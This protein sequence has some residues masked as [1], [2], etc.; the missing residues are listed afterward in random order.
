MANILLGFLQGILNHPLVVGFYLLI[1]ILLIAFRKKFTFQGKIIALYRTK[2][3]LGLMDA[4]AGKHRELVKL[5]GYIGIGAGFLSMFYILFVLAQSVITLLTVPGTPAPLSPVLPG[6]RIPGVPEGFFIPF[7]QGIIAIFVIAV[8]HEFAHGVVARAHDIKIKSSGPAI[9][10]PIFAAF[11]EP[12]EAQ[13]KRKDDV[14][15]LSVFAAGTFSNI[16]LTVLILLVMGIVFAPLNA[17]VFQDVGVTVTKVEPGFPAAASGLPEG[18]KIAALNGENVN[19]SMDARTILSYARPGQTMDFSD[20]SAH[21]AVTATKHPNNAR[22]GYFG[23][24][25]QPV[26]KH[27]NSIVFK[28]YSW[29]AELLR[30]IMMLSVGIGLANMIPAG[31]LDGGKMLHLALRRVRGEGQANKNLIQVSIV[32][33][34]VV[35]FLL[36]P[37]FKAILK[38]IF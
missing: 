23:I 3:G 7:I 38:A 30:L 12:D 8:V 10:G 1:I 35:I 20:G 27:Q 13:M 37:I 15:N 29:I 9:I 19:S 6:V 4:I 14:A 36:S 5:F 2:L 16:V 25:M 34:I 18:F 31:P 21:Y 33:L 28:T 22:Q 11:V 26:I 32:I 24:V 17:H